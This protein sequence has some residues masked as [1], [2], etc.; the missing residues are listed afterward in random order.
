MRSNR[1]WVD[2]VRSHELNPFHPPSLSLLQAETNKFFRDLTYEDILDIEDR[3]DEILAGNRGGVDG[4]VVRGIPGLGGDD[5][6]EHNFPG[7]VAEGDPRFGQNQIAPL[8]GEVPA[9]NRAPTQEDFNNFYGDD[10]PGV[11]EGARACPW[12]E[13]CTWLQLPLPHLLLI[14]PSTP[15]HPMGP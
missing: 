5:W 14:D 2:T 9:T 7:Q 13:H 3:M 12:N 15:L 1:D 11:L 10:F 6:Q 4:V 8:P